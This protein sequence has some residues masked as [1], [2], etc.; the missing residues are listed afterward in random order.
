MSNVKW[1]DDLVF[2]PQ[3]S[4]GPTDEIMG[5][6]GANV[7]AKYPRWVFSRGTGSAA[8]HNT[9]ASLTGNEIVGG[10]I[11]STPATAD[12]I[13]TLPPA[14]DIYTAMGGSP[15][16]GSFVECM[17]ENLSSFPL[18]LTKI[19]ANL[20]ITGLV[21]TTIAS[22]TTF[23]LK[24]SVTS[25]SPIQI[26]IDGGYVGYVP[27]NIPNQVVISRNG[28]DITGDGSLVYPSATL[29]NGL[30][31]ST[32]GLSSIYVTQGSYPEADFQFRPSVGIFGLGNELS[33]IS[34]TNMT[35]DTTE[36]DATTNP[37]LDLI[38]INFSATT[39]NL[40]P[41][42]LKS[43]SVFRFD[44]VTLPTASSLNKCAG[45]LMQNGCTATNLSISDIATFYSINC[46]HTSSLN[47]T[48]NSASAVPT[49][50]IN[51]N[52]CVLDTINLTINELATVIVTVTNAQGLAT[53]NSIDNTGSSTITLQFDS[54]SYPSS[55]SLTGN[56]TI[57]LLSNISNGVTTANGFSLS[58]EELCWNSSTKT[59]STGRGAHATGGTD[60]ILLGKGATSNFSG[61]FVCPGED[62]TT[63]GSR[64]PTANNQA[65]FWKIGGFGLNTNS[66]GGL[67]GPQASFHSAKNYGAVG[68]FLYSAAA[69][70]A[71]ANMVAY[72]INPYIST[73]THIIKYKGSTGTVHNITF[74]ANGGTI[75]LDSS[76]V[77][78]TGTENI[79][80]VK[81]FTS[82]SLFLEVQNP[83]ISNATPVNLTATTATISASQLLGGVITLNPA[84]AQTLTLPD[85]T[86]II[87][88]TGSISSNRGFWVVFVN[89][90]PSATTLNAGTNTT[91]VGCYLTGLSVIIP[92][93]SQRIFRVLKLDAT[94]TFVLFG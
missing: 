48:L 3:N 30:L 8:T 57:Q 74:P 94:P 43:G 75:P 65:I 13:F 28:S 9:N 33:T 73:D 63:G 41:T 90:S 15:A 26:T 69:V 82:P 53:F 55:L 49:M 39:F 83:L 21:S 18:S 5:L 81:T 64:F 36:W 86:D 61:S 52:G 71:D 93:N 56:E 92:A 23:Y 29:K 46:T 51:L 27:N 19:D 34:A 7:N 88:I 32:I 50:N 84:I 2:V 91:L 67:E 35:L 25:L 6:T 72:E 54:E 62:N 68:D 47:I 66:S 12:V 42:N 60:N 45:L 89:Q 11:R 20:L 16:V 59:F 58:N 79:G 40:S 31:Q 1:S 85:A 78:T 37:H 87:A 77:H 44:D 14:D 4:F 76:V 10:I 22:S 70:I 24:F 17:I 38:S 80:G